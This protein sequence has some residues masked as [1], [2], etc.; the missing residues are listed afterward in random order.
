L[1]S[2][3]VVAITRAPNAFA[4]CSANSD[5]PPEPSVST[6]S[7][8]RRPRPPVSAFQAVTAAHGKHAASSNER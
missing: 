4:N 2:L 8:E 1:L 6:V 7:P 5:T 3:P